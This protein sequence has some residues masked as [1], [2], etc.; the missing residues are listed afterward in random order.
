M[1][2]LY[3]CLYK[4][5][6][7]KALASVAVRTKW[8]ECRPPK[9]VATA[10]V[11]ASHVITAAI[12]LNGLMALWTAFD[13]NAHHDFDVWICRRL[14]RIVI[15]YPLMFAQEAHYSIKTQIAQAHAVRLGAVHLQ[16]FRE[17]DVLLQT[18]ALVEVFIKGSCGTRTVAHMLPNVIIC[19]I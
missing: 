11:F 8:F 3:K 7:T 1:N 6:H 19:M 14:T 4:A 15:R 12:F 17:E 2:T 5:E 9:L 16:G 10:T 18:M 13:R